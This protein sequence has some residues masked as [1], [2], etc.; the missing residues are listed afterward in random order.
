MKL[1]YFCGLI[2][3]ISRLEDMRFFL[4]ANSVSVNNP[5][6]IYFKL[7]LP[8]NTDIKLYKN[9]LLLLQYM[10]NEDYRNKKKETKFGQLVAGTNYEKYAIYNKFNHMDESFI[11]RKTGNSKFAFTLIYKKNK[12][13][14]W[15]DWTTN[16]FYISKDYYK[17]GFEYSCTLEDQQ[18]NRIFVKMAKKSF[19]FK[20]LL[21]AFQNGL[22]YYENKKIKELS[23][24]IFKML[25]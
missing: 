21:E 13:G 22:V 16:R 20:L 17:N 19:S 1:K 6:F 11:D 2:E 4:L 14:V 23:I 25:I 12:L 24:D 7:D 9:G 15:I 8:Y 18:P 5:Y 10:Y 3:T